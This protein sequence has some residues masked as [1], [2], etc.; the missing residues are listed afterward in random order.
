MN[1]RLRMV[2]TVGVCLTAAACSNPM[3]NVQAPSG[4][5][6][7]GVVSNVPA[8]PGTLVVHDR[9][10]SYTPAGAK[11]TGYQQYNGYAPIDIKVGTTVEM[12]A[13]NKKSVSSDVRV[14][15]PLGKHSKDPNGSDVV[16]YD[17]LT[18]GTAT[19]SAPGFCPDI[20][21]IPCVAPFKV[22]F[23]IS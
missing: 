6:L 23:N 3:D 17:A 9:D 7:H 13:T 14:L 21:T 4:S 10:Y 1:A 11:P 16:L 15:K 5:Q 8:E 12:F 20:H 2:L 18:P 22:T 19:I